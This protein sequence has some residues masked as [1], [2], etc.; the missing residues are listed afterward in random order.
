MREVAFIAQNKQYWLNVERIISGKKS[1]D[2]DELVEAY[3]KLLNDLSF[4]KTYY[5]KS[6]LV[7]Y[8]NYLSAQLHLHV[9]KKSKFSLNRV[10]EFFKFE[11]PLLA[12]QYRKFIYFTFV[13]FFVLVG[14]GV[15]SAIHDESFVRFVLGDSYVDKTMENIAKGNPVSIY[16]N[17][18]DWG[19][20]IGIAFNNLRVGAT[21]YFYGMIFGLGTF[22]ILFQNS[23]MLGAFQTMFYLNNVLLKSM[24]GIWIHGSIEIFAMVIEAAMG[25]ALAAGFIFPQTYSRLASFKIGF[26]STFKV[27]LSTVPFTIFAAFLEGYVTRFAIEM[28]AFAAFGIIFTTLSFITYY[29]I[30][31]PILLNRKVSS[32]NR[33]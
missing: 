11:V 33:S 15:L 4:S 17:G 13:L 26:K 8:L 2:P 12:Y 3:E 24:Q 19:S 1:V 16:K 28:G 23:M 6:K 22:Y 21:M 31:Y 20:F 9:Y 7:A 27:Y 18:S 32:I 5:S 14:I 29:Y 10:L 25:F 30:V